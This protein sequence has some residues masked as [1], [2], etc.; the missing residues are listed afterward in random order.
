LVFIVLILYPSV[1]L[2]LARAPV[3]APPS[4]RIEP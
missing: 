4:W 3:L 1:T 2:P